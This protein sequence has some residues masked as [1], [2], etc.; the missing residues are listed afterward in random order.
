VKTI[1]SGERLGGEAPREHENREQGF[2]KD[3]E[4]ESHGAH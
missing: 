3:T 2:E 4:A 1:N